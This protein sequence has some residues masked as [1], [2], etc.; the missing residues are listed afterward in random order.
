MRKILLGIVICLCLSVVVYAHPGRTDSNGGHTDHDTGEYHYH[1][2]YPEHQHPDM[3]GDGILDCPYNFVDITDSGS[4]ESSKTETHVARIEKERNE[5]IP[6]DEPVKV[7]SE[8]ST[9]KRTGRDYF[10]IAGIALVAFSFV[11]GCIQLVIDKIKR[12]KKK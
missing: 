3:D 9:K 10:V 6:T 5:T 7:S 8:S 2:G 12:K 1:H 4:G 11:D